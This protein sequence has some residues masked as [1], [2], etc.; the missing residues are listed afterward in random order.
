M[1]KGQQLIHATIIQ[2][3]YSLPKSLATEVSPQ[4]TSL[5]Q[6]VGFPAEQIHASA[7]FH[8]R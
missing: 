6:F 8:L 5:L 3:I 7:A 1:Y 2:W 4:K